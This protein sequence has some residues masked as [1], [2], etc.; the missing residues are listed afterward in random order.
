[1]DRETLEFT[2]KLYFDMGLLYKDIVNMLAIENGVRVSLRLVKR[3][4]RRCGL[5]RRKNYDNIVDVVNFIQEQLLT[6]GK[7]HGYRWMYQKCLSK[8]IHCKK[9]DVRIILDVLDPEGKEQ[10]RKRR[11][12][13]RTYSSKGPDY[14]WHLDSYDK[15]KRYGICINGCVVGF[16]RKSCG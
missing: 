15:L 14:I 8:N 4:L 11:L 1:M 12:L 5:G 9:E 16:S 2:I 7:L 10:R 6:S 13:R 3:Y